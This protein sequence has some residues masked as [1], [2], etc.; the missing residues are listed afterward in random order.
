M[1]YDPNK[2]LPP[3]VHITLEVDNLGNNRPALD[4]RGRIRGYHAQ[5]DLTVYILRSDGTYN[6]SVTKR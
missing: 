3:R 5:W 6:G 2:D 4:E 1:I